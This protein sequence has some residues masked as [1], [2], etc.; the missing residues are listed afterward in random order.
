MNPVPPLA[1]PKVPDPIC[2]A[3]KLDKVKVPKATTTKTS[4]S[5]AADPSTIEVPLVAV[6][7][8]VSNLTPFK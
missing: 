2:V 1:V 8:E 6:K 7:S 5:C 3:E 4:L